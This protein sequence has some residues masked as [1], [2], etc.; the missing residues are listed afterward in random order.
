MS[1]GDDV[2]RVGQPRPRRVDRGD[3]CRARCRDQLHRHRRRVL[4]GRVGRDRRQ[5]DPRPARRRRPRHQGARQHG[6]RSQH[7]RELA[8]LDPARVRGEPAAPRHRLHRPV[9]D[10]PAASRHRHRRDPRR[11]VRPGASGQGPLHREFHVPRLLDRRGTVGVRATQP[12]ALRVRAAA[13]LDA[14]ARDRVRRAPNVREVRHR[15]D[16]VESTRGRVGSPA[17]GARVPT[18]SPAIARAAS[19]RA[20]TSHCPATSRSSRPPTRSRSSPRPR[21]S[22]S[23]TSRWRGC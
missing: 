17:G 22:R 4:G 16:P 14:R 6:R 18:T 15:G 19:R 13:V 23:C 5:G 21:G 8:A 1:R 2:R 3:P 20:T 10:A 11:T 9:P 12:R 7:E